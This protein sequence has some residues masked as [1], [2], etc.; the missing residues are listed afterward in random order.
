VLTA[1]ATPEIQPPLGVGALVWRYFILVPIE[2]SKLGQ[3][4]ESIEDVDPWVKD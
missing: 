3:Q 1:F 4:A 2:E